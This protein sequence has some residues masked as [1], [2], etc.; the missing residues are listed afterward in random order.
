M[1]LSLIMWLPQIYTTYKLQTDHALSLI[2]NISYTC[3]WMFVNNRLSVRYRQTI[4]L[5]NT[6]LPLGRRESLKPA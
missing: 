1:V 3:I 6:E 5:G 2:V 4:F